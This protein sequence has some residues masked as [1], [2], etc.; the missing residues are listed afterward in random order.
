MLFELR[1]HSTLKFS[2]E[3]N[4]IITV[5]RASLL[6]IICRYKGKKDSSFTLRVEGSFG[7]VR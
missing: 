6:E 7:L 5:L 4:I 3:D 1:I 2:L